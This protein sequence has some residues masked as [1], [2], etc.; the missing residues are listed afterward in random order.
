MRFAAMP[1][2]VAPSVDGGCVWLEN[3]QVK[4]WG[5]KPYWA[6]E[7]QSSPYPAEIDGEVTS[8]PLYTVRMPENCAPK[9]VTMHDTF[10]VLCEGGCIKCWGD[11]SYGQLGYGDTKPRLEPPEE[12]VEY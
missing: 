6:T 10:C 5:E 8:P 7:E 2:A 4:C 3:G 9:Q 11:N 1:K 12:C